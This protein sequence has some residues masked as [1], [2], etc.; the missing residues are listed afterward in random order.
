MTPHIL[1]VDDEEQNIELAKIILL[2]EG[3]NLYFA[4][5]GIDALEMIANHPIDVVVLD[6]FMPKLDGFE[7]LSMLRKDNKTLPVI[8]VTAFTDDESHVRA[9][10]LGASDVMTKPYDIIALKQR[11]KNMLCSAEVDNTGYSREKI[12]KIMEIF[13]RESSK[14]EMHSKD[15]LMALF[16]SAINLSQ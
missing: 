11:V 3:Y 14:N 7:T 16:E 2:K 1:I 4:N 8:V 5:N 13:K 12:E 6:L 15:A 10:S 9:L